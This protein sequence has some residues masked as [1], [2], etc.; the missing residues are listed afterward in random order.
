MKIPLPPTLSVMKLSVLVSL[1][2]SAATANPLSKFFH[3]KAPGPED[4]RG[5]CPM[6]N[7]LTNHGFLPRDGKQKIDLDTTSSVLKDILN[8]D[9]VI[10][11]M[12]HRQ[13]S[14]TNPESN[15]TTWSLETLRTHNIL[16]HDASLTRDDYYFN[17]DSSAF[18]QAAYDETR[19][20]WT[21][22]IIDIKQAAD[23]RYSRLLT[24]NATNPEFGL[25]DLGFVFGVGETAAYIMVLGDHVSG[26][27]PRSWV[28]YLFE[29]EKLP[30]E[31]GWRTLNDTIVDADLGDMIDRVIAATPHVE[32][33]S[34]RAVNSRSVHG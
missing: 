18:S 4:V 3:W 33:R 2:V 25:S 19:S 34:S 9:P 12:L 23:A 29:K 10:G 26:T 21:T 31:L 20:F 32:G 14:R 6:L 30:I 22:P 1:L 27:V 5:P 16:E 24:S 8:I 17:K 15:A 7:S 28:Q 13:A 11:S